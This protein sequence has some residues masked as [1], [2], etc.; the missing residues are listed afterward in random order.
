MQ[1]LKK[2]INELIYMIDSLKNLK[3]YQIRIKDRLN[4]VLN[5]IKVIEQKL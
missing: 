5:T 1:N 2:N 4:E 3:H